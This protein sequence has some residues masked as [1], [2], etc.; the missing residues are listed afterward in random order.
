MPHLQCTTALWSA[1]MSYRGASK[2]SLP[3]LQAPTVPQWAHCAGEPPQPVSLEQCV[4]MQRKAEQTRT[5]GTAELTKLE[6]QLRQAEEAAK[7]N[8]E[9][10]DVEDEEAAAVKEAKEAIHKAKT[11]LAKVKA[12]L[13]RRMGDPP[14]PVR[15]ARLTLAQ[16]QFLVTQPGRELR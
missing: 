7:A 14:T 9:E 4:A 8:E 15:L 13:A 2:R 6:Q 3:V 5:A 1:L 11:Y 10:E 12:V 16:A